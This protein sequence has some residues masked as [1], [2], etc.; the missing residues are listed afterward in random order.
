MMVSRITAVLPVWRSPMIS[1]RWPRPIGIS[2]SIALMPVCI[3]SCTDLRGMM[4]GAFTSTRLRVASTGSGPCRRSGCPGAST[5]RPSRPLPTGTSTMSPVR[6]T[7]SPSRTRLVVAEDHDADI[8]GLEVQRH[9]A[10]R[11]RRGTPPARRPS[12]S[13]GRRRGRCRRRRSA[14]C[15][16]RPR[17]PRR[18]SRRSAAFRISEISAGRISMSGGPLHR[19]LQSLQLGLDASCRRGASRSGRPARRGW[20]DPRVSGQ[21]HA[22]DSRPRSAAPRSARAACP[23]S[24]WAVV[25]LARSAGRGAPR[26][27]RRRRRATCGSCRQPAVA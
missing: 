6:L 19:V 5:T 16:P 3:G 2:A 4:P 24:A 8:V 14:R 18:R 9:A 20:T 21:A 23:I 1:S 7:V 13:A 25:D 17:S 12:R 27:A 15:R 11:R 10:R 26:A 22:G